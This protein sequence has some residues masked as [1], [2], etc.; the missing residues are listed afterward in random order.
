MGKYQ[1]SEAL[2]L[3]A[4]LALGGGFMD[5]Y[6]YIGRGKVFANA[7]T[8]NLLLLGVHLT[9][10]NFDQILR[11][12]TPVLCFIIG[13]L[14]ACICNSIGNRRYFHWRQL[15]LLIEIICFVG[16]AFIPESYNILANSIISLACG[17]QVEA[18]KKIWSHPVATTMCI[19]NM[20]TGTESL[21]QY[22]VKKDKNLLVRG[23]VCFF[24]ILCFIIGAVIGNFVLKYLKLWS[25]LVCAGILLIAL[26]IMFF[27]HHDNEV[28]MANNE[29]TV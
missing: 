11:Y 8:G 20:R 28:K 2:G 12:L 29:K 7:Q 22:F 17:M 15:V 6:S 10:G 13:V 1:I 21:Y 4:V 16:V 18:F 27:E 24:I 5:A 25:I 19:G 14:L 9:E 23:F 3:G 26:I